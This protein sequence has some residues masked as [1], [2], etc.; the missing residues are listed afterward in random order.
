MLGCGCDK[1][2]ATTATA[3][4]EPPPGIWLVYDV[5]KTAYRESNNEK[6]ELPTGEDDKLVYTGGDTKLA[7]KLAQWTYDTDQDGFRKDDYKDG[8]YVPLSQVLKEEGQEVVPA[9]AAEKAAAADDTALAP[10][11]SLLRF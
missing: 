2:K 5:A 7:N 6:I 9:P 1:G 11:A 8:E 4:E 10:S 3:A